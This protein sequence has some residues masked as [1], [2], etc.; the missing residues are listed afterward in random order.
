M[1]EGK[2]TPTQVATLAAQDHRVGLSF[3]NKLY[4]GVSGDVVHEGYL[5]HSLSHDRQKVVIKVGPGVG[6]R[7]VT[8]ARRIH[9]QAPSFPLIQDLLSG[10]DYVVYP[11]LSGDTIDQRVRAGVPESTEEFSIFARLHAQLWEQTQKDGISV[12]DGYP[13]K[14]EQTKEILYKLA[15]KDNDGK[16]IPVADIAHRDWRVNGRSIGRLED[17]IDTTSANIRKSGM[18]VLTHGDEGAGNAIKEKNSGDIIF[19]DHG[20]AG[21]RAPEEAIAKILLWFDATNVNG[22]GYSLNLNPKG[23]ELQTKEQTKPHIHRSVAAAQTALQPYLKDLS[24]DSAISSYMMVY[25]WRELHWLERRGRQDAMPYL[26]AKSLSFAPELQTS[27]RG[28][29]SYI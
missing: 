27:G 5:Q 18:G 28:R 29:S 26:L 25:L 20:S 16:E 1:I 19:I 15:L 6:N 14:L 10:Y 9:A 8:A 13:K 7:E 4:G 12:L 3:N 2:I 24:S 17:V 23:V 22:R 11:Y 21:V